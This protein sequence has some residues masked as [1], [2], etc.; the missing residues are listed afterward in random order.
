MDEKKG[1][2]VKN[3]G[4]LKAA[5]HLAIVAVIAVFVIFIFVSVRKDR[6]PEIT[7]RFIANK[8]EEAS[9][10]T[11]ARM[12]YNG[13]V[14]YSDGEIPFLTQK[15]FTMTYRAEVRAGID[16]SKVEPSVTKKKVTIQ[17]PEA[18]ILDIN[19]DPD[20]IQYYDEKFALFNGEKR[21]DAIEAIKSARQDVLENGDVEELKNAAQEQV[22]VLLL[23]L[24]KDSIGDRELEINSQAID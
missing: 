21:E 16:L 10:L 20:S 4:V 9:E 14:R 2:R 7:S 13:L 22:K 1:K 6:E 11:S 17:V 3:K 24:F 5:L 19:V 18:E 8:L 12:I 15:A 23:G